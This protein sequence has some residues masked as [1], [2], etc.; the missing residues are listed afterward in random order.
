MSAS[1][2]EVAARRRIR[3]KQMHRRVTIE[4]DGTERDCD[5][6]DYALNMKRALEKKA[7]GCLNDVCIKHEDKADDHIYEMSTG[8]YEV[9]KYNILHYFENVYDHIKVNVK[10]ISDKS[11]NI[12]ETQVKTFLR[13]EVNMQTN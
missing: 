7:F 1:G 6:R 13:V 4:T 9:Y 3:Q 2:M 8:I 11:G 12:V 5:S 10:H